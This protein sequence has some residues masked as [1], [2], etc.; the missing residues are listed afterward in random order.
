M[1][2]SPLRCPDISD[3]VSEIESWANVIQVEH[4]PKVDIAVSRLVS[5]LSRRSDPADSLIDAVTAWENLVG[6][7]TETTFRVTVALAR[8]LEP[9]PEQRLAYR[10]R[11]GRVYDRRSRVVHGESV[12]QDEIAAAA[13]EAMAVAV[14]A[15]QAS[16]RRG[17]A[18]L[19][20]SSQARSDQLLLADG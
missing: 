9:Q 16:Y 3:R 17:H 1:A 5:A 10:K 15:L 19:N 14:Q 18:W 11:L 13:D 8:L 7:S 2:L 12:A 20:L 4:S 6:T